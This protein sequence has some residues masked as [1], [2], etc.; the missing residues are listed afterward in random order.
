MKVLA[1]L[2]PQYACPSRWQRSTPRWSSRAAR[3]AAVFSKV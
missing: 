2:T 3:S 1:V